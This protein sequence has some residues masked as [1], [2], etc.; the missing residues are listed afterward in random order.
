MH[1]RLLPLIALVL[2]SLNLRPALTSIAPLIELIVADTGLSR[3]AVGLITT[4]PV[5]MMGIMA[6]VSPWLAA[7]FGLERCISAALAIL[8]LSLALR[9]WANNPLVLLLTAIG[10][11]VGI[12]ICGTLMAGFIKL[13]FNQRL[14][15]IMPIYTLSITLG[16][17]FGLVFTVPLLAYL[18]DWR[19]AMATWSLPVLL[20]WCVWQ[21]LLPK[22]VN[23]IRTTAPKLPLNSIKA[24][25]FTL[26]FALQSGLFY[27]LTTWLVARYEEA[28]AT[29]VQAS[30]YASL[31]MFAGLVGAFIAPALLRWL[32]KIYQ[33]LI[34][35]N[36]VVALS[37]MSITLWPMQLP[38]LVCVFSGMALTGMFAISLT[39]PVQQTDTPIQA[40]SLTSMMLTFGFCLGSLAPAI[41]GV[42]RDRSDNYILPFSGLVVAALVMVLLSILFGC[43]EQSSNK[44]KVN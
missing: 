38:W 14:G 39:L 16:A 32:P 27:S 23:H 3:A 41:V 26:L 20:A 5:L 25:I 4:L 11:G 8:T 40:A 19:W 30:H 22:Q 10:I 17:A 7:R 31:F 12:A 15:T 21:P 42:L 9:F 13:R 43:F 18:Q 29:L 36:S 35:M 6:V 44:N 34:V 24:W 33:L 2:V 37:L 28:G 1:I